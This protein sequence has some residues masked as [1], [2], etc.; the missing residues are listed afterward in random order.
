MPEEFVKNNNT[1]RVQKNDIFY[2]PEPLVKEIIAMCPL[3]EGDVVL[4]AWAGKDVF[5]DNYPEFVKKEWC[6]IERGRDFFD[7][8]GQVDWVISN[9]PYSKLTD[10]H[11]KLATMCRKGICIITG[12]NNM[13]NLRQRILMEAGFSLTHAEQFDVKAWNGFRQVVQL[14]EKGKPSY[15]K[16]SAF[17]F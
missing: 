11:R 14:W 2:T 1:A 8:E 5:Y 9:P 10:I 3:E 12:T 7:Y 4:D 6:E 15:K 17:K 13:T 16:L